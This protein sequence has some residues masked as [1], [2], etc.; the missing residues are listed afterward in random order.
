MTKDFFTNRDQQKLLYELQSEILSADEVNL[1]FP[2][3]SK[4]LLNKIEPVLAECLKK[5]V[6]IKIITTTFDDKALFNNLNEL[7]KLIVKY[8]NIQIHIEDNFEKRSERIHIKASIFKRKDNFDSVIIGSSNLTF[9]GMVSGREWNVKLTA[10]DN[11]ELIDKMSDEF[12]KLWNENLVNFNNLEEQQNLIAKIQLKENQPFQAKKKY[13]YDFQKTVI[14]KLAYRRF[15]QKKKHLIIMATG[16]GKTVVAAFDYQQQLKEAKRSLRLL[17]VAHQKEIVDQALLTF[18]QVLNDE[19][20]GEVLYAG[21][22]ITNLDQHIFATIQTLNNRLDLFSPKDFD[23]IIFDE[24]HHLAAKTFDHVFNYF[25]PQQVLGLTATPEREDGQDI[26]EYFDN[27]Y[28][29]EIRIW[30]AID[31]KLLTPFDYYCIDD[32]ETDLTGIDLNNEKELFKRVNTDSRNELLYSMIDRYLGIYAHPTALI[33]CITTEHAKIIANY[34]KA[35]NL[36]A[37]FLTSENHFDRRRILHDF[38]NG[39]INYLCVVNM[40]NEGIDVPEINTIILLRPTNSKTIYLQQLGRGLRKTELKNHLE[41]YDL[42]SNIDN[43]Y[44]LTLGLKNLLNPDISAQKFLKNH[45]G[46][47]YNSTLFL[48]KRS[49]QLILNNLQ[50][51]Y[52]DR[53]RIRRHIFEYYQK[54]QQNSLDQLLKDYEMDLVTFYDHLNDLFMKSAKN[55]KTYVR[56][57]NDTNRNKNILKQ[58][59]F[60]DNYEVVKYFYDR[61]TNNLSKEQINWDLDNL[62]ITS[63]LYEITSREKFYALYPDYLAIPDLIVHFMNHNQ[64]IVEELIMILKYKL[65]NEVL[66]VG[67]TSLQVEC[68]YTVKQVLSLLNRTNFLHYRREIM[69]LTFQA[70]YLTFN[71]STQL[72]LADEDNLGYGKHTKYDKENQKFY[73]SI[74]EEMTLEHKII[75][76]FK[77]DDI[78]KHLFIHDRQNYAYKNMFLKLYQYVGLGDFQ[79]MIVDNYLTADFKVQETE[80]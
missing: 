28:A 13:L 46:L 69:V 5:Q 2:F 30:D 70:G 71:N 76:D 74:P 16:T 58:F 18:R 62:L 15:Q 55:I 33:F 75:K 37:D 24:A 29:A 47:P 60:L 14:K 68:T 10:Q 42:I 1:I 27:E 80:E 9:A 32:V 4:E 66:K 48:E 19:K 40:F 31:Q 50:R 67:Q 53:S 59:I 73:W 6:P 45:E 25:S 63:C 52:E 22:E 35:K 44:D 43:R 38:K 54:Y 34:L 11:K 57:E 23:V 36:R 20:F 72:I 17:F 8:P 79:Q 64:L 51:W 41:V 61:L 65:E 7:A 12:Q 49:E 39:R 78:T 77:N 3:I 26:K 56:N 21:Q